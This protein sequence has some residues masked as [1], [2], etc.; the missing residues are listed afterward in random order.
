M[1]SPNT[2]S[3]FTDLCFIT[4]DKTFNFEKSNNLHE[5][6]TKNRV[7][8][9]P[10]IW[11]EVPQFSGWFPFCK[12]AV[13]HVKESSKS[14]YF[15]ANL[16]KCLLSYTKCYLP[17]ME[18]YLPGFHPCSQTSLNKRTFHLKIA[19]AIWR[20]IA[21]HNSVYSTM[22]QG[23]TTQY[24]KWI[25][26][27]Y[28]QSWLSPFSIFLLCKNKTTLSLLHNTL[29]IFLINITRWQH[30]YFWNTNIYSLIVNR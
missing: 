4:N 14:G 6:E 15:F 16:R 8:F 24:D 27:I 1:N 10:K 19:S 28:E 30:H 22:W 12:S 11:N 26:K 20:N 13:K 7:A 5:I 3:D 2:Y 29:D 17:Q 21:A 18:I 9:F 25:R 23:K